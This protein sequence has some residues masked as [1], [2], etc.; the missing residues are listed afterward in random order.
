MSHSSGSN[1]GTNYGLLCSSPTFSRSRTFGSTYVS[2][3][4]GECIIFGKRRDA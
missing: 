1:L 3:P 4:H 2:H